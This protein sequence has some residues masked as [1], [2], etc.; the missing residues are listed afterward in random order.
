LGLGDRHIGSIDEQ[1]NAG[2]P[3]NQFTQ[4]LQ[5]LRRQLDV[6][7]IDSCH[8]TA[9]SRE[10]RDKAKP[11]WII[12]NEEED[13]DRRSCGLGRE[14]CRGPGGDDDGDTPAH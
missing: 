11:H 5:P 13:G 10:A 12:A 7:N 8:V 3:G 6:E 4:Q 2:S 1:G 9:R 14:R